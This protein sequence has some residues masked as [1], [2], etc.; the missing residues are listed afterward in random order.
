MEETKVKLK[1]N[2]DNTKDNFV[3]HAK[4]ADRSTPKS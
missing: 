4:K 3:K 2:N 1:Q